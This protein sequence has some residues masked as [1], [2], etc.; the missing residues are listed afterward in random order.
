MDGKAK[1]MVVF[2]VDA[3]PALKDPK[4]EAAL[5]ALGRGSSL[6]NLE[7]CPSCYKEGLPAKPPVD[8]AA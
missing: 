8:D 2:V 1:N 3:A 4:A 7:L 5:A 6:G